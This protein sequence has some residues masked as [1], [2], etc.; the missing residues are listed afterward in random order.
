MV[1]VVRDVRG[2]WPGS[3][4]RDTTSDGMLALGHSRSGLSVSSC[5][6]RRPRTPGFQS[7]NAGSNPARDT[8]SRS[9]RRAHASRAETGRNDWA[10]P[11]P[12]TGWNVC[13]V[14]SVASLRACRRERARQPCA[15]PQGLA[16]ARARSAGL[17]SRKPR[18]RL[19]HEAPDQFAEIAQQVE[20]RV[21]A[22]CVGG[23]KPSLGTSNQNLV[24]SAG[25]RA[26]VYEAGGRTF[27]SCTRCQTR[28]PIAQLAE[29]LAVN[30]EDRGSKPRRGAI[31]FSVWRSRQR[32][33][34]GNTRP[35]VRN[36]P[37]R[38]SCTLHFNLPHS[39]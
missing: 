8:S 32:A 21:E 13:F 23:S 33:C 34:F 14:N 7:G 35:Q 29:R 6:S 4:Q 18:V 10:A 15:S 31:L 17:S 2:P 25:F 22:A 28:S 11:E 1:L 36:L 30:Q 5:S 9:P 16:H 38:P 27:E 24:S 3:V 26:P 20:R 12:V 39:S 19:P 37:P